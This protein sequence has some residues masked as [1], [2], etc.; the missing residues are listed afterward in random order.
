[1]FSPVLYLEKT[2]SHILYPRRYNHKSMHTYLT[3]TTGKNTIQKDKRSI[4]SASA[5]NRRKFHKNI[6]PSLNFHKSLNVLGHIHYWEFT[7]GSSII[8]SSESRILTYFLTFIIF[9][10]WGLISA[11]DSN[12]STFNLVRDSQNKENPKTIFSWLVSRP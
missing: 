4:K 2:F 12:W 11:F 6:T 8:P 9:K 1:M 7:L 3:Y 5:S 10:L